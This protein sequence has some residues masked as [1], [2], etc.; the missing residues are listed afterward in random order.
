[1]SLLWSGF[2]NVRGAV[3]RIL[4]VGESAMYKILK[5][6]VWAC[7]S[8]CT[9]LSHAINA[10]S[11][12]LMD[13]LWLSTSLYFFLSL[14]LGS[15][16]QCLTLN[17]LGI[18]TCGENERTKWRVQDCFPSKVQ[19]EVYPFGWYEK[20]GMYVFSTPEMW[21]FADMCVFGCV[22]LLHTPTKQE[23]KCI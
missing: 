21:M 16:V 11:M 7:C 17:S 3:M 19:T 13:G 9:V 10:Y 14:F 1:M 4:A 20:P 23:Y 18:Q 22:C 2:L 8:F 6:L 5:H 12:L 15:A